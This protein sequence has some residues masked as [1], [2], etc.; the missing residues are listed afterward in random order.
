[1]GTITE[2]KAFNPFPGLRPFTVE[3]SDWFFGRD[4]EME[5][6]YEKLLGNRFVTLIGS[7]GC[8]K[9][10]LIN[11]GLIPLVKHAQI[12]GEYEW[13][14]ISFRP[15]NDPMGNLASA[16]SDELNASGMASS[17]KNTILSELFDNPEG[18]GAALRKFITNPK[19]KVLLIIDQFEELFRL[20][21]KGRKEIVAASVAKFVSLMVEVINQP[22]E[23]I[24]SIISLRSDFIGDCSRYHG[25]TQLINSSNY[26]VPELNQENCR[27]VIEG[28][29]VNAGAKVESK[30]V[31]A[32]LCDLGGRPEQLPLLQ[33][34]MQRMWSRWQLLEDPTRPL[35]MADYEAVGK[36]SSAL[37]IHAEELF[38]QLTPR[39]RKICEV[40]FRT[41]TEKGPDNRGVR[42]P[43][44]AQT[45]RHVA[46]CTGQELAEIIEKFR[47]GSACF[48]SP[49]SD[50]PISEDT[51]I[52]LSQEVIAR[53]WDRFR[54]WVDDE[55]A[56]SR[57]YL[58]L[59]EASAMYQQ[60]KAG[61]WKQ[62]ELQ[63]ALN[64][65]EQKNPTLA[66]AERYNPAF[67]RAMVFLRTSERRFLEE[68]ANKLR[69][70]KQRVRRIRII[71]SVLGLVTIMAVTY[72]FHNVH[73]RAE[74]EKLVTYAESR[75]VQ[76]LIDRERSDST[77][78]A[79][80]GQKDLSDSIA[81]L[82]SRKAEEAQNRIRKE[83]ERR[84]QAELDATH[85]LE[86]RN[87]ALT[88]TDSAK[89]ALQEAD[90]EIK[91]VK[92]EKGEAIR[93]RMVS[94]GK[95]VS[96]KSI[97]L[98][99][100]RELQ[101]LLAYQAYLFNKR[102]NGQDNDPD[103]YAALYKA[104]KMNG[105]S[106]LKTFKGHNGEI[107]S[108]AF[109][110]GEYE[111]FTS[112]NDGQVLRWSLKGAEKTYQVVYTGGDIVN[113]LAV[114]PDKHWLACGGD[115]AAIRMIPLSGTDKSFEMK[116]HSG[117]V[118]SL[119]FSHDSRQLYSAGLDGKV[120]KWEIAAR[121]YTDVT[122]GET[123]ITSVDISING[124]Y[125]A[126]VR[127]DGSAVVWNPGKL[128]DNFS[129]SAKGKDIKVLKFNPDNNTLALGDSEG[130]LEIW[131]V[132]QRKKIS[133]T[134]A[135]EGGI[136]DI[137]FNPGQKQVASSGNDK[138]LKIFNSGDLTEPPV[139]L[140]DNDNIVFV[141]EF[142]PDAKTLV[143][144]A[145]G[146]EQNLYSRPSHLDYLVSDMCSYV[147]R[148]LTQDEWNLY[149]GKDIIYELTCQGK[150]FNI[151]IDQIK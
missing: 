120:L 12:D 122:T 142:S 60:G 84:I 113:V 43:T 53:V 93:K 30:L 55:T 98:E 87:K 18:I 72:M 112:G 47:A 124:D 121:T 76:A 34:V 26:L 140:T 36:L 151:K 100:Q 123:K 92:S 125:L 118:K 20:A 102:N 128:S 11:C 22:D 49:Y 104:A 77:T 63:L 88:E 45:I 14:I 73:R 71:A 64:W 32:I 116:G 33:H 31:T 23:N 80:L 127:A 28:P 7:A 58:R 108:I 35:N 41:I 147:S 115:N 117:A 29:I 141:V 2:N 83:E 111:F 94:V 42:N 126:G 56:S 46:A 110:P 57:M 119:I 101:A 6:V 52:D 65:R 143:A 4:T 107:R 90:Q 89:K 48:L 130:N 17:D 10:S 109:V 129:I 25:L 91:T 144:G 19:E 106:Q 67:E 59:S 62:P 78:I 51:V 145:G 105:S 16:I 8:G 39:G 37:S 139:T 132:V 15:G 24:Y 69:L 3:E 74:S 82:A 54:D 9:T 95:T 81:L 44:F 5:E 134:K 38:D 97:L 40:M 137:A 61:L 79:V 50:T 131:D 68:E 85:A 149:V 13:R 114:S 27:R 99:G 75:F 96:V 86:I 66:W 146:G 1:M 138:V 135:H 133:E 148:N 136:R 70:Q 150:S 103:V 21:S